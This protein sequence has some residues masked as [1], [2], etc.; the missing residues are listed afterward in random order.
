MIIAESDII[1]YH[2]TSPP[3]NRVLILAP[4]PDDET[5]G[6][7]GAIRLYAESKKDIKVVFLTSGDKADPANH[8]SRIVH[9][10]TH[11]TDY[12]FMREKEAVNAL[13]V[14]GVPHSDYEFLRFPDRGL[15][16]NYREASEMLVQIAGDFRP[17]IIYS[18]SMIELNP[19]HR[20]AASLSLD[21]QRARASRHDR[22]GVVFYEV[23]TPLRPNMLVDITSVF[24]KKMKA[25]KKYRSQ[26]RLIDYLG[27]MTALNTFRSLTV[28]QAGYIEAFWIVAQSLTPE[29]IK[30][31]L[32]YADII[33]SPETSQ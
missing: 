17:D 30:K 7:G 22:V 24:R 8:L 29:E 13:N 1:P 18:P 9:N 32:G 14:L 6:C 19:D 23:S 15:A 31:W 26:L 33:S 21:L 5:L 11:I 3:G 25:I 2:P 28:Q 10:E 20:A 27:H 16:E 12:S 4:H